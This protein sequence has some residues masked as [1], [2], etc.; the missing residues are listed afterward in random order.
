MAV[1]HI[2]LIEKKDDATDEQVQ[3]LI[4]GLKAVKGVIPGVEDVRINE[5]FTDRA[6]FSH[7][8]II[9]LADRDALAGYGPHPAHQDVLELLK[10][11]A[12][13]LIIVDIES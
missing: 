7:G 6:P 10:P 3:A 12:A 5:N 9:T 1:E 4:E 11:V 8:A 2:V 13:N